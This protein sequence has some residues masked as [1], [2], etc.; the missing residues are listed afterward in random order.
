[1]PVSYPHYDPETDRLVDHTYYTVSEVADLLH[2]SPSTVRQRIRDGV[3]DALKTGH[4]SFMDA[5]MIGEAVRLM[6][7]NGAGLDLD[8]EPPTIGRPV[9]DPDTE[10][11]Q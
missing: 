11:V 10:S 8:L 7:T 2:L 5:A 6:R 3:Y 4:G 1:M 9:S